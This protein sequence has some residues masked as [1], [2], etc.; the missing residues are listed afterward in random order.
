MS[1]FA[2]SVLRRD[3]LEG[4]ASHRRCFG[5]AG[6]FGLRRFRPP[7]AIRV[8]VDR[9]RP[10]RV[11]IDRRGMPGGFVE[12]SAGPWR[13]SGVWWDRDVHQW[14]ND[15]WDLALSDGSVCRV[16]RDRAHGRW[17]ME[18]LID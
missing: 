15:E 9:G 1:A 10:V 8:A 4:S 16:F 3:R 2:P 7:V 14:N 17:F 18:A 11:A 5:E 6:S 12:Q 13:S